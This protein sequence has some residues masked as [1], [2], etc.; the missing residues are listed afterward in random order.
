MRE[1]EEAISAE[2]HAAP[3]IPISVVSSSQLLREGLASLLPRYLAL[4]IVGRYAGLAS[5]PLDLPNP[6]GHVVLVD[7]SLGLAETSAWTQRWRR[8][9]KP[10][11]VIALELAPDAETVL[12]CVEAGVC[13]YTLRGASV[14]EVAETILAACRGA[15]YCSPEITAQL[16]ARLAERRAL[17]VV[18]R[19]LDGLTAR[20][21]EVL[22]YLVADYSN[23][24]IA[25]ALVIEVRTV[26]HH[27]HQIL[28]KLRV[29]SRHAAASL[30]LE[31]GW[32]AEQ[33]VGA[34]DRR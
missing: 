27:V 22:R 25:R 29:Q 2:T 32:L 28:E 10:A 19:R 7:G 33:A 8:L 6:P 4:H 20:E 17:A 31:C 21:V 11:I 5:A 15:A 9:S 24:E 18:P 13:G 23:Q 14:A 30:A 16:F 12:A 26:K 3:P 1:R 34:P